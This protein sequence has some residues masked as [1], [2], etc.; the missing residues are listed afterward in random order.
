MRIFQVLDDNTAE[1]S[2]EEDFGGITPDFIAKKNPR[3]IQRA[4]AKGKQQHPS[5]A[6]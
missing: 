3:N 1:C 4:F 5:G 6:I 2:V